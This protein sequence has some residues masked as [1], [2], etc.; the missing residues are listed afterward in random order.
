MKRV[1]SSKQYPATIRRRGRVRQSTR[2]VYTRAHVRAGGGLGAARR[3]RGEKEVP[4]L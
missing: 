2:H 4:D 1:V 3:S